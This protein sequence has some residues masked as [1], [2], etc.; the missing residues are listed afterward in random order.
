MD[1]RRGYGQTQIGSFPEDWG[2]PTIGELLDQCAIVGH[3]DGNHGELYPRSH[4]FKKSGV[5]YVTANNLDGDKVDFS[6]C[7]YLSEERASNFRKGVA[8]NGDVLFAHNATVGPT[9]LLSTVLDHVILSTT[10]TYFRCNP[11][12]LL[13]SFLLYALQSAPFVAQY[14]AVMTQSTRNQVPITT[15]RKL[16]IGLPPTKTEQQAIAKMLSAA[17]ALIE[18]QVRLVVKK[19]QIKQGAMQE[20]LTGKKRLAGQSGEW[21]IA[22]LD[23]VVDKIAGVWGASTSAPEHPR[24]AEII[25]AGDISQDGI[26]TG[27]AQRF[28]SDQEFARVRCLFDDVL[29]T[30]S[31]NGLGKVWRCDGRPNL[32]ASNFVRILRPRSGKAHG[33]YLFYVLRSEA[34]LK[35]LQEHTATSAY[36]NLRPSFFSA[37]WM[38]LPSFR[39]QVAITTILSEMDAEIA[40]LEAKLAK[41]QLIKQGMMQ[42][43]LTGKIRLV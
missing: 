5:P 13:N 30:T 35:Q 41:T 28:V 42:E 14:R 19:R 27:T 12:R 3:E 24:C 2:T 4:E 23:H 36:P 18:S 40:A 11:E 33:Q 15:Q 31:G 7:K 32:A 37:A 10:V 25:R 39:E 21:D 1:V 26:L 16:S 34:G 20:L 6:K 22:S 17:D 38:S 8:K 29:M 43:L 9:A